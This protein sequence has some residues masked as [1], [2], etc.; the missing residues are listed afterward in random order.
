MPQLAREERE[1]IIT[2]D[3]TPAPAVIFTHNTSWQHHLEKRLGI[4]P[5]MTNGSGGRQYLVPKSRIKPPR[6]PRQISAATRERLRQQGK[7]RPQK[8]PGAARK[9]TVQPKSQGKTSAK[10]KT[11]GGRAAS[12]KS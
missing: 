7:A 9:S 2:F 3:E 1:T 6:A 10:G 12:T 11:I 4:K 8:S 5:S